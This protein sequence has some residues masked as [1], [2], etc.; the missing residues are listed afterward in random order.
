M[1][2]AAAYVVKDDALAA[3]GAALGP[4]VGLMLTRLAR[5]QPGVA[6]RVAA[7]YRNGEV[8]LQVITTLAHGAQHELALCAF[9]GAGNLETLAAVVVD[10]AVPG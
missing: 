2:D 6:R 1:T 5:D 3:Y 9:D 10:A 4:L 8:R 7:A